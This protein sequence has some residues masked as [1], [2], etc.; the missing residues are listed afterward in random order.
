MVAIRDFKA[1]T[2]TEI[3]W[4]MRPYAGQANLGRERPF[5]A[6]ELQGRRAGVAEQEDA[7]VSKTRFFGSAGSTP[8]ARTS[9]I[10]V[11][12]YY[13]YAAGKTRNPVAGSR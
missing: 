11:H 5:L 10:K 9:A 2:F 6:G 1:W 12:A 13:D 8:A 7:R 3:L 4:Q